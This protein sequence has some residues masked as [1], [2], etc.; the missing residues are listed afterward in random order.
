MALAH[1]HTRVV[2]LSTIIPRSSGWAV[3]LAALAWAAGC[4]SPGADDQPLAFNHALHT[5]DQSI[6]C[7]E[8]HRGVQTGETAGFPSIKVC[9]EC[10]QDPT[11]KSAD[12]KTL[13]A[14]IAKNEELPWRRLYRVPVHVRYSHA[15]HVTAGKIPCER[16]HGDI[17]KSKRPPTR[18]LN[19]LSMDF[20]LDC[21][22]ER[23]ATADCLA[24]HK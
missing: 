3:A 11:T 12:E 10:H 8:C 5:Q 9:A 21:H 17:A 7:T 18:A 6:A 24:C 22:A 15:R 23:K 20:C 4:G 19:D 1:S 2:D 13:L 14:A 16:C